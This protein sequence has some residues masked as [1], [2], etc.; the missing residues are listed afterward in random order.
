M[1]D[2]ESSSDTYSS[3]FSD[4]SG[5]GSVTWDFVDWWQGAFDAHIETD[6]D[7]IS[8][9]CYDYGSEIDSTCND[10]PNTD[11]IETVAYSEYESD[12]Q[13][14]GTEDGS[15]HGTV[16][17]FCTNY[18]CSVCHVRPSPNEAVIINDIWMLEGHCRMHVNGTGYLICSTCHHT[19]HADC[20]G[21]DD[22]SHVRDVSQYTC[23]EC[24]Q[25]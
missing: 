7:D 19:F 3:D 22:A 20:V 9:V 2:G 18:E 24:Q 6:Q 11:D 13:L 14:L 8:T 10:I 1:S 16:E 4:E 12:S 17:E 25:S 21:I 5:Y 15:S 23:M